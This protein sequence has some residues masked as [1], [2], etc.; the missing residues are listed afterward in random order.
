MLETQVVQKKLLLSR[1]DLKCLGIWQNNQT[2]L[3]WESRGR[4]P[5][6]LRIAG[7]S[8][9]WLASEIDAWLDERARERARHVYADT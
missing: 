3:R 8:V 9:C 2:L 6:R 7:T 5:R 1:T 4:F